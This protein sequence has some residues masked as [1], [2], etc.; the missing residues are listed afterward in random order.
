MEPLRITRPTDPQTGLSTEEVQT[1][2]VN[3][4]KEDE[5][6]SYKSIFLQNFFTFFNIL[7]FV[8]AFLVI[9]T[10]RYQNM[11]FLGIVFSNIIIGSIQEIRAKHVLDRPVRSAVRAAQVQRHHIKPH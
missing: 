10:G 4:I 11:M 8:L 5:T 3:R 2:E 9:L 6:K 1:A 7:N